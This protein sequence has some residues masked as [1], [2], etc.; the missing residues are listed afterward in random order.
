MDKQ[1]WMGRILNATINQSMNSS[2][3]SNEPTNY[4]VAVN[5]PRVMIIEDDSNL[6]RMYTEKFTIENFEVISARDGEAAYNIL[7]S[8]T[9]DCILLDLH[10]PKI[11]G[12]ALIEKLNTEG[13]AL[14]PVLAL[15]NIAELP[16]KEKAKQLGIKEYMVKAMLTPEAVV[17]TVSKYINPT[18]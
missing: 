11:D 15:T 12:L 6:L 4:H 7:K 3:V 13:V 16:Q 1:V 17:N 18:R 2:G 5:K 9:P 10:I 8:L 14:P